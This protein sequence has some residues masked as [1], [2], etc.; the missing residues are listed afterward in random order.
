MEDLSNHL[1]DSASEYVMEVNLHVLL[2]TS[3]LL[4]FL[5]RIFHRWQAIMFPTYMTYSGIQNAQ[6]PAKFTLSGSGRS[7]IVEMI[8]ANHPLTSLIITKVI[9]LQLNCRKLLPQLWRIIPANHS[10]TFKMYKFTRNTNPWSRFL[11]QL[12]IRI[13]LSLSIEVLWNNRGNAAL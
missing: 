2:V 9:S 5:L 13:P 12:V 10:L 6:S 3:L 8:V 4:A 11:P 7:L 1:P